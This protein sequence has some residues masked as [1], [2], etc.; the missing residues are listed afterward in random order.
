MFGGE[1]EGR[2]PLEQQVSATDSSG[3]KILRNMLPRLCLKKRKCRLCLVERA[4]VTCVFAYVTG[5]AEH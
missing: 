5:H 1:F 2:Y 4:L 3:F